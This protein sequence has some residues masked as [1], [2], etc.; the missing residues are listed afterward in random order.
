MSFKV[1]HV[2]GFKNEW[3][4][5]Q[6][7]PE[8]GEIALVRQSDGTY[9]MKIGNGT[10]K[11]SELTAVD[12]DV[13]LA[14]GSTEVTPKNRQDIRVGTAS[15]LQVN[16][17]SAIAEDYESRVSFTAGA[18]MKLTIRSTQKVY[19]SGATVTN[20]QFSPT[21]G[22]R[23]TLFFWNDGAFRCRIEEGF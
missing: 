20:N 6:F 21:S 8:D 23:Y 13:I 22:A 1:K 2:R 14:S 3:A 10:M 18:N 4:S 16:I 7:V 17:P 15:T 12:R 5:S 9:R 11:F 19:Y